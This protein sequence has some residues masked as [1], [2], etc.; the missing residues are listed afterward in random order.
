MKGV[1]AMC[2]QEERVSANDRLLFFAIVLDIKLILIHVHFSKR[3]LT[4]KVL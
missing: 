1:G 3:H 4:I 2:K